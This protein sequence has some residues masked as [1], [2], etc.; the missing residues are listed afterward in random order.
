MSWK[1][2]QRQIQMRLMWRQNQWLFLLITGW[3]LISGCILVAQGHAP[4]EALQILFFMRKDE[5]GY[6][7]FYTSMTDFVV[8]G[9]VIS[10]LLVD[11][12][13]Q[14]RPEH[15]CQV[16]AEELEGHAV[17][18]HFTNLGKRA[19]QLFRDH[20]IPVAVVEPDI[21]QLEELIREGYPC[22]VASGRT[23]GDLESVNVRGAKLVVIACDDLE[24]LA[25]VSSLV[26]Q[27]NPG[28]ALIARCF[29]DEIGEVLA[30][31][32]RATVVSTS[33][34][35]AKYIKEYASKQRSQRAILVGCGSLG[36]RLLP[37]LKNL[38]MRYTIIA[39]KRSEVED[40]VD[41]HTFLFGK[42][43][44]PELLKQAGV[45][46]ADLII[47]SD[48]DLNKALTTVDEIRSMNTN[49]KIVCRV[50]HDD[51][52]DMLSSPPFKCD[53]ISTSRYAVEQLRV[54]GAFKSVGLV[55]KKSK[56]PVGGGGK[57]KP[58]EPALTADEPL[59]LVQS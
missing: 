21:T 34:L 33:R 10:V 14:V 41:E 8:F 15:T 7:Y 59:Q 2:R 44:D 52:A 6:A 42:S 25:V 16:M 26:R 35:A 12:Q 27:Q 39:E 23:N 22:L 43:H 11:V 3:I 31:R 30:K 49:C 19:W 18:F 17:I 29:D 47:L 13:R 1:R 37:V 54:Q 55:S 48:D 32:Y 40:I 51:A 57:D 45:G 24:T 4:L 50:F 9:L 53:V 36:R 38:N 20:D 5:T 56:P 58:A 28:C 46:D